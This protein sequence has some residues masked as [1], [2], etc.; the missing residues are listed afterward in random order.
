RRYKEK[1]VDHKH[2]SNKAEF[3]AAGKLSGWPVW[4]ICMGNILRGGRDKD[5]V[6]GGLNVR[7]TAQQPE[8]EGMGERKS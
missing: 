7:D 4:S 2:Q 1:L 3:V 6:R 5:D 8:S